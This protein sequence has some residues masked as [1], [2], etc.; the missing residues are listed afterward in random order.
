[1]SEYCVCCGKEIPEGGWVCKTC[2]NM[3]IEEI[4]TR[5]KLCEIMAKASEP[6]EYGGDLYNAPE[7]YYPN[8]EDILNAMLDSGL[9]KLNIGGK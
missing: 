8:E 5:K 2:L 7:V 4:E 1:M 6:I 3:P 9:I